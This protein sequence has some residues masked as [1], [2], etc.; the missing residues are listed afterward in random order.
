MPT[1]TDKAVAIVTKGELLELAEAEKTYAKRTKDLANAKA[2]VEQ[3]RQQLAEKVL[4]ITSSDEL[5]VLSP[6][7]V[8]KKIARRA[9]LGDWEPGPGAPEFSF[10]KTHQGRYPAWAKLYAEKF[11]ESVAK[12]ITAETDPVYSYRVDVEI[13][14]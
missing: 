2:E 9:E 13:P 10:I 4:G 3:L 12:Q 5:K 6:E 7:K 8:E 14:A 11:G 1:T